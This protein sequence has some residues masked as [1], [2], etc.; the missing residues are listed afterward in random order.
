MYLK[1]KELSG[2]NQNTDNMYEKY[3]KGPDNHHRQTCNHNQNT[4]YEKET[5]NIVQQ[6]CTNS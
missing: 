5:Q 4:C 1:K 2:D 3:L 6:R